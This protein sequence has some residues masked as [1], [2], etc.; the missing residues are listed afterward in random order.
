MG[1]F[2]NAFANRPLETEL[3]ASEL[4]AIK[5]EVLAACRPA[6]I[7]VF[8]SAARGEARVGSDLDIAVFAASKAELPELRRRVLTVVTAK[9]LPVDWVFADLESLH[10]RAA[11]HGILAQ[12]LQDGKDL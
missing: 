7:M 4:A 9:A 3:I 8:G 12:I 11:S 5:K 1:C 6:R 10:D 2:S